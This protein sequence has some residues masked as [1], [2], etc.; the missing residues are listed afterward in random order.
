MTF[1]G[2]AE[3]EAKRFVDVVLD[4]FNKEW[5]AGSLQI[6]AEA[7]VSLIRVP[8]DIGSFSELENLVSSNYKKKKGGSY[9]VPIEEI[10]ELTKQGFYETAL[11]KAIAENKL[12]L[13]YQPIWS[14]EEQKTVSCEALLRVD[15]DELRDV[16][17]EFYIPIAEKTG[18]IKDIGLFVFEE[19]CRFLKNESIKSSGIKYVELN[20][21]VYQFM[22]DDIFDRF[23][24]IR[25]SY[26]I[27]AEMINLEITE[28]A[29]ASDEQMVIKTLTKFRDL[30]YSLS[31]DDFGTGYSNLIRMVG[32]RYKNIKIDK[33]ILWNITRNGSDPKVLKNLVGFIKSLGFDI[34]QEGVET[35]EQLELVKSC[36]CDFVQGYYFSVPIPENEFVGYMKS[37]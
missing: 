10:R 35:E 34:I 25:K 29:V 26:G 7:V 24:E 32:S 12:T 2:A 4:R 18:L 6:K 37:E 14:V 5:G 21:S 27:G 16:S 19:V 22:Y 33:S 30:G 3:N 15:C 17:P 20:L 28:T 36:G 23:E 31:L 13:K 9:F 8:E 11:K 1:K